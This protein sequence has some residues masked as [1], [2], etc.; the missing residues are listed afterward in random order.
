M[1]ATLIFLHGGP[2]FKDYLSPFFA[3]LKDSFRC[4]FYD[5][6]RGPNVTLEDLILQLDEFVSSSQGRVVL[7]GHS[8]GGVL[9]VEYASRRPEKV[10]GLVLM[11]TGLS[12][13]QWF[14]EYHRE[15]EEK[16]LSDASMEDI[17][18]SSDERD[19]GVPFM[20]TVG[21]TFSAETFERLNDRYLKTYDL[22]GVISALQIP[23]LNIYGQ[24][25]VRFSTRVTKSFVT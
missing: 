3:D 12:H 20:E 21:Q 1:K 11:C 6:H 18:L 15:L 23:I 2:G 17:F 8:W 24:M 9:G 14:D 19:V 22:T 7:V 10:S 13:V 5:Q 4:T 16:G 25:D